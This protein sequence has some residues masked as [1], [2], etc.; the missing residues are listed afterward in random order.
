MKWL[1]RLAERLFTS[2]LLWGGLLSVTFHT[3]LG[4]S[5]TRLPPWFLQRVTGQWESYVCTTMF[6]IALAFVVARCIGLAI[7]VQLWHR[8]EQEGL[9]A[10]GPQAMDL[11]A[12]LEGLDKHAWPKR[13]L[14]YRRIEDA[15]QCCLRDHAASSYS[16]LLKALSEADYDRLDAQYGL[17]R[18][19]IWAIPSCGSV[20]TILA[21]AKVVERLAAEPSGDVLTGAAAGLSGAFNLFAFTVGLAVALVVLKFAIEQAEQLLLAAIDRQMSLVISTEVGARTAQPL[22]PTD[23]FRQLTE[24][25]KSVATSLAQQTQN[26]PRTQGIAPSTAAQF[27]DLEAVVQAAVATALERQHSVSVAGGGATGL[28][29]AG[30]KAIQHVLQKLAHVL[31]QQNAKL[32]T[33]GRVSKHLTMIID[34]GLR[35]TSAPLGTHEGRQTVMISPQF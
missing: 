17:M 9:L 25:L 15:H 29:G 2:P 24:M 20:A 4:S 1:D 26:G 6:L 30:W 10:N 12:R 13:S 16:T 3:V 5:Q 27:K 31:E 22:L 34:E 8:I 23:Q 7:Q 28:D 14:L 35:E 19:L 11:A 18:V 21:I 32:E 33:E